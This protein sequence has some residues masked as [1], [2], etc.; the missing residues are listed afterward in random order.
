MPPFNRIVPITAIV[1]IQLLVIPASRAQQVTN[2]A[3]EANIIYHFTRYINWPANKKSG[4]FIIGIVGDTP[5]YDE[6]KNFTSTKTV[7]SQRIVVRKLPVTATSFNCQ[8][9]FISED[10]S[11]SLKKIATETT[12]DPILI[13]TEADGLAHKGAC[14]NFVVVDDHLK[15][16]INK[17]TIERRDLDIASELLQLGIP[18]K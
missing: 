12:G 1:L 10:G 5:L 17:S 7:G 15:L 6:L 8:I 14:I 9:L 4:D 18:V 13:V 16:E 11:G 3:V 2:Y